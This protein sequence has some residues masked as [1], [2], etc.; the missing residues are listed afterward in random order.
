[1]FRAGNWRFVKKE[2]NLKLINCSII[3]HTHRYTNPRSDFEISYS[4][5]KKTTL[6]LPAACEQ[7]AYHGPNVKHMQHG[8]IYKMINLYKEYY[9]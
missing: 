6:I 7:I 3:L 2:E 9:E 5:E 8:F 1:M 4:T